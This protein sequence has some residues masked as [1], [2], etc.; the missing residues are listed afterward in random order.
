MESFSETEDERTCLILL[1]GRIVLFQRKKTTGLSTP[2]SEDQ[3]H[4]NAVCRGY[5]EVSLAK[6]VYFC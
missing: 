1:W 5:L 2:D 4:R 3:N 6:K